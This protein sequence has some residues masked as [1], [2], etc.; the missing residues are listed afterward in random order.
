MML[1]IIC[2][3]YSSQAVVGPTL[4]ALSFLSSSSTQLQS[5][6]SCVATRLFTAAYSW[7][8]VFSIAAASGISLTDAQASLL[9]AGPDGF[10]MAGTIPTQLPKRLVAA[11][12]SNPIPRM[13]ASGIS[14]MA[15][16]TSS[17]IYSP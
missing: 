13:V 15:S 9:V 7:L 14:L 5:G 12:V 10:L 16:G 3:V 4:V 6:A 17:L 8:D 2:K 11:D 1:A